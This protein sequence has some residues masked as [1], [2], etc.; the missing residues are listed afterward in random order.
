MLGNPRLDT[1]RHTMVSRAPSPEPLRKKENIQLHFLFGDNE[2]F[3]HY[4][5]PGEKTQGWNPHL[6]DPPPNMQL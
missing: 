3:F 6:I 5:F 1:E 4:N 2:C